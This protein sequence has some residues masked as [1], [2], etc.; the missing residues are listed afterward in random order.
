MSLGQL[1]LHHEWKYVDFIWESPHQRQQAIDSGN[2]NASL[3]FLYDLDRAPDGR[4]FVTAIRDKGVPVSVTTITWEKGEGGPLL[5]PYPDWSWYK[6]DCKGITGGVYKL[7]IKCNHL[8]LVDTGRIGEDQICPAQLLIFDLSTDKLVKRVI[9]PRNVAYDKNGIGLLASVAVH[10]SPNC[11][12]IKDTAT[13]FMTDTEGYGLVVYNAKTSKLCRIE[14]DFMIPTDVGFV[15]EGQSFIMADGIFS[16]TLINED[17]YYTALPG[18][19]IYKMN[20]SKLAECSLSDSEANEIT[21][22][23]GTLS[24]QTASLASEECVIFF[25][26][27][28][29]TSIMCADATK[30]IN[31]YNTIISL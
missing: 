21:Q 6:D 27:I 14:S 29:K 22:L 31:F 30:E 3:I 1:K 16:L 4:R 15:I 28:P 17:L 11:E 26:N 25:S 8:F 10:A 23:V 12:N 13:V 2:Y 19:K 24:D 5:R 7:E 18:S 20:I 9:I